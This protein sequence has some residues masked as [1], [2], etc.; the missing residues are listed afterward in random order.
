MLKLKML[1]AELKKELKLKVDAEVEL[2][3]E[4]ELT[5]ERLREMQTLFLAA[6]AREPSVHCQRWFVQLCRQHLGALRAHVD[7][8][9]PLQF[10]AGT[11]ARFPSTN[12]SII[13]VVTDLFSFV[14]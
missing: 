7:T 9:V 4:V 1:I 11:S 3:V 13:S 5:R 2:K 10:P 8:L 6:P 12:R 14:R